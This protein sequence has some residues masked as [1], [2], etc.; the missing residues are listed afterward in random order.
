VAL[1]RLDGR[2][3][4]G[5]RARVPRASIGRR[6]R[7]SRPAEHAAEVLVNPLR[8]HLDA[9]NTFTTAL[10]DELRRHPNVDQVAIASGVPLEEVTSRIRV[11][12]ADNDSSALVVLRSVS[13]SYFSTLGIPL[14]AGRA[15]SDHVSPC[16][17]VV[18][19]GF[20][21]FGTIRPHI[22]S[23]LDVGNTRCRV[24]G[25][26][27]N[28][29][30]GQLRAP[31]PVVYR[32]FSSDWLPP[33]L[34]I[35]T[36]ARRGHAVP[37]DAIRQAVTAVDRN[38]TVEQVPLTS[39]VDRATATSRFY[40]AVLAVASAGAFG[41][42]IASVFSLLSHSVRSRAAAHNAGFRP[43]TSTNVRTPAP[44]APFG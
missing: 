5:A 41:L 17:I 32:A 7:P 28:V 38:L 4:R 10:L 37:P 22:G 29:R 3:P 20:A 9:F 25:I 36:T 39:L 11:T 18:S 21:T 27:A 8:L 12:A 43:A 33:A 26:A 14:R 30:E 6:E 23:E 2:R 42:V 19:D 1:A 34:W 44:V 16:E 31:L 24:V 13:A 15:H 35:L 40:A